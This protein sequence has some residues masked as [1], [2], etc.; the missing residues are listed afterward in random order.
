MDKNKFWL[1][2]RLFNTAPPRL[3]ARTQ[4][5]ARPQVGP[6]N[7]RPQR[8]CKARPHMRKLGVATQRKAHPQDGLPNAKLIRKEIVHTREH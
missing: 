3:G 7:A 1:V 4:R 8:K 2:G 5:K 6:P